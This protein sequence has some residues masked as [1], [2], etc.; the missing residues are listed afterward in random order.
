M[1]LD[2]F[3]RPKIQRDR[4]PQVRRPVRFRISLKG[5]YTKVNRHKSGL[6]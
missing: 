5:A 4:F 1:N 2:A 3:R 6:D